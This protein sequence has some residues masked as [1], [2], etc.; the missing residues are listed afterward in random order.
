ML[1]GQVE[2]LETM[3]EDNEE[4][5]IQLEVSRWEANPGELTSLSLPPP[6]PPHALV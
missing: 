4:K 2:E 5:I 1:E 6:P 3:N